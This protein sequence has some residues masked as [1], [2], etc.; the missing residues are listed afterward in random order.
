MS[1]LRNIHVC[2]MICDYSKCAQAVFDE[3]GTITGAIKQRFWKRFS[4]GEPKILSF[5]LGIERNT[6]FSSDLDWT[7][8]WSLLLSSYSTQVLPIEIDCH[9]PGAFLKNDR[10]KWSGNLFKINLI[11]ILHIFF[12]LERP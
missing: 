3:M 1:A 9:L 11:K 4:H 10:L 12:W 6:D 8:S 7:Q 2:Q 5:P